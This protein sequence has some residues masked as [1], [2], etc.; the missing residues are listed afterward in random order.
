V[1]LLA[2]F[3]GGG[4]SELLTEDEKIRLVVALTTMSD[5][6]RHWEYGWKILCELAGVDPEKLRP[7]FTVRDE[8]QKQTE[9]EARRT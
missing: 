9:N 7:H 1:R 3:R 8:Q 2:K 6:P 5:R 4:A